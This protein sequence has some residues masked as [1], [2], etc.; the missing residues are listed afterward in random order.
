M[1]SDSPSLP[2]GP[3]LRE[4][5]SVVH[6]ARQQVHV[7][8][9]G[10]VDPALLLAARARLLGAME[11]YAAELSRCGLP[12]PPGLRDELRLHRAIPGIAQGPFPYRHGAGKGQ[13]L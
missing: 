6:A 5:M 10:R 12:T 8:R 1:E 3:Q 11:D 13:G 7:L 9:A 2:P 4:L